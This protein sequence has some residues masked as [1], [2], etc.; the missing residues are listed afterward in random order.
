MKRKY[1][2]VEFKHSRG[3][4]PVDGSPYRKLAWRLARESR[5]KYGH[6]GPKFRVKTYEPRQENGR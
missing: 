6:E 2:V 5:E 4:T 1:F 3:W